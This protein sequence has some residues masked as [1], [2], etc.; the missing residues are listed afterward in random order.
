M[1]GEI[2]MRCVPDVLDDARI[3]VAQINKARRKHIAG[4]GRGDGKK[5]NEQ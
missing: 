1:A 3:N 2:I 5:N 4:T